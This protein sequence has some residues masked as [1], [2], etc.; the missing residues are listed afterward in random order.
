[1]LTKHTESQVDQ[2]F[3]TFL[4][5]PQQ[6]PIHHISYIPFYVASCPVG[7]IIWKSSSNNS[8]NVGTLDNFENKGMD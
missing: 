7:T 1:M 3:T 4:F 6:N 8:F 2:D 5:P